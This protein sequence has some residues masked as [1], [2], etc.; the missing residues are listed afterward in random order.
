MK[1]DGDVMNAHGTAMALPR[2]AMEVY[3][4]PRNL[5]GFREKL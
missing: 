1:P 3:K 2:Q 4:Q 5:V